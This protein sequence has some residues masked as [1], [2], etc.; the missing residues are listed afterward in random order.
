MREFRQIKIECPYEGCGEEL[1]VDCRRL[2]SH[3][4]VVECWGC[5]SPIA[6]RLDIEIAAAPLRIDGEQAKMRERLKREERR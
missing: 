5:G 2:H 4:E 6:V 1:T 3:F